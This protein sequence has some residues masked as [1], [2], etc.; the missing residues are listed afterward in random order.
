M[1]MH[2]PFEPLQPLAETSRFLEVEDYL[3][4]LCHPLVERISYAEREAIRAEIRA[5]IAGLVEAHCELGSSAAEATAAALYQIGDPKVIGRSLLSEYRAG[6]HQIA[7]PVW[8]MINLSVGAAAGACVF[9]G[10]DCLAHALHVTTN[11]CA[12]PDCVIGAAIGWLPALSQ[13]RRPRPTVAAAARS[14][15]FYAGIT[16]GITLL[17][18]LASGR[19]LEYWW[20]SLSVVLV[21]TSGAGGFGALAG[22]ATSRLQRALSRFAPQSGQY[23]RRAGR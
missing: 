18:W 5:H 9:A 7:M 20:R 15:M 8:L 14:G 12:G 13:L 11:I 16:A 10:I 17:A 3:D 19:G 21:A 2:S 6:K 22:V 4:H 1:P 23:L